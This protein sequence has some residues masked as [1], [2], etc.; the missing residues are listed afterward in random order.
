MSEI[1]AALDAIARP[2]RKRCAVGVWMDRTLD[3]SDRR[4]I[5]DFLAAGGSRVQ[6]HHV[7]ATHGLTRSLSAFNNHLSGRCSC[8]H[9]ESLAA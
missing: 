4:K 2:P 5:D 3:D 8:S 7:L 6:A 9:I 1:A